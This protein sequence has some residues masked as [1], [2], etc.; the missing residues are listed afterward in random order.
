MSFDWEFFENID[1]MV[2]VTNI[3]NNKLEYMNKKTRETL[4]FYNHDYKNN[5]CY[6]ILQ[7]FDNPCEFCTNK[8]LKEGEFY[9]WSYKNPVMNKKFL[10]KDTIVNKDGIDY[11]IEIA[12][13]A[14]KESGDSSL[15]YAHAEVVIGECLRQTL[16]STLASDG[17]E[18]LIKYIGKTFQCDRVYIFEINNTQGV[19]N[20]YEWCAKGIKP[21]KDFLQNEPITSLQWWFDA[22]ERDELLIIKDLEEIKT[23]YPSTYAVLKPQD[24]TSLAVG[25][26]FN[27]KK[28]TGFIGVDNPNKDMI[29]LIC[30]LLK[31]IGYFVATLLKRRDLVDKLS[32][33]SFRDQLTGVLNRNAL[34]EFY[35][36]NMQFGSVGVIYCDITGLKLV[37]DTQGHLAGDRL[38]IKSTEVI[39]RSVDR[40]NVYRI[41]GDEFIAIFTNITMDELLENLNVLKENIAQEQFHIAVGY[42]W[43]DQHPILIENLIK[44]ADKTMYED[45][46]NYYYNCD[47]NQQVKRNRRNKYFHDADHQISQFNRFLMDNYYD[48]ESIFKSITMSDS[49]H[50]IYFGDLRK[51]SFYISDNMRETFG[52]ESNVVDDFINQWENRIATIDQ[53][54]MHKKDVQQIISEKRSIHDLRYQVKDVNGNVFWVRCYGIFQ[55]NKDRTEPIFFSGRIS[56]QDNTFI[57]DP[58]TNFPKEDTAIVDLFKLEEPATII[59]FGLNHFTEINETKGRYNSN[60][61]LQN[62]ANHMV[63]ELGEKLSFYRLDGVKF[64][65]I[66]KDNA[67]SDYEDLIYSLRE[68]IENA[69]KIMGITVRHPCSFGVI[70]YSNERDIPHKL[71]EDVIALISLAKENP[72]K[73]YMVYYVENIDNVKYYANM[74][75]EISQDAFNNMENFRVVM[76][77]VVSSVTGKIAAGEILLRWKFEDKDVSPA[78]FIPMLEKGKTIN[79]AGKWVV[80]QAVRCCKRIISYNPNFYITF[81]VSYHQ[82]LDDDFVEYIE[83]V[84][85]KYDLD[86]K[87]IVAELTET[88]FDGNPKKL[89]QFVE[90]CNKLGVGVAL[91]DFGN[92]YSS[93][94]LLLKYPTSIVKLDRS[95]MK[96]MTESKDKMNFISSIVY[97]CHKFGKKVCVEGVETEEENTIVKEA[98]C[99]LIQGYYYYK[100]MEILDVY[101]AIS[102][103]QE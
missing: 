99:D 37:N 78:T 81:N 92:G 3:A 88:H 23:Q 101:S 85:K 76:Q 94:G 89:H 71:I 9:S 102:K 15:Y 61:M 82:V 53:R 46:Q 40:E 63:N 72:H 80:E 33:L 70:S 95:L 69:Y 8:Y 98:G 91:D 2:Y 73:D 100:P 44:E 62:V 86:G 18:N 41:G 17:I 84:L 1:E 93:L 97:A 39:K 5:F 12:I 52:F 58:V 56:T 20:T 21:Q 25:P 29:P 24:I 30:P 48:A 49:T 43:S 26:I 59:A 6:K 55:W 47:E 96:E 14:D 27:D 79:I 83:H 50:Y 35:E 74:A 51:N 36:T 77:P 45:K 103:E 54:K 22:F 75:L 64:M 38:I 32:K 90:K 57:V 13:D 4:G 11:R 28:I 60:L 7:G 34:S 66:L 87:N 65:A 16:S 19:D 68:I 67:R 10:L 31:V 42:A